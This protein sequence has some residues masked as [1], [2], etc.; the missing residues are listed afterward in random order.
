MQENQEEKKPKKIVQIKEQSKSCS[1][2]NKLI[3]KMIFMTNPKFEPLMNGYYEQFQ[4]CDTGAE[5][6]VLLR[7]IFRSFSLNESI[8]IEERA[9]VMRKIWLEDSVRPEVKT[10]ISNCMDDYSKNWHKTY[11]SEIVKTINEMIKSFGDDDP[12]NEENYVKFFQNYV[13]FNHH[14]Q[15]YKCSIK[16]IVDPFFRSDLY[17]YAVMRKEVYDGILKAPPNVLKEI[18]QSIDKSKIKTIG[19]NDYIIDYPQLSKDDYLCIQTIL[20]KHNC[21]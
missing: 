16:D 19:V 6:H 4:Q 15:K 9:A 7:K 2:Q 20:E 10:I 11:F 21:L 1:E 13:N 8:P 5:F 17:T 14:D 12:Y 18:F 3:L